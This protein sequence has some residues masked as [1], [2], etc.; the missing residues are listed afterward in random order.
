MYVLLR[1]SLQVISL[2]PHIPVRKGS[3]CVQGGYSPPCLL[4]WAGRGHPST[5]IPGIWETEP[6]VLTSWEG[7]GLPSQGLYRDDAFEL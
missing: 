5:A 1:G 3:C 7:P 6:G 2:F 4:P